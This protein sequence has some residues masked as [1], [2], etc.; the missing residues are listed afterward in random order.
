MKY[1]PKWESGELLL[2]NMNSEHMMESMD[3]ENDQEDA[4]PIHVKIERPDLSVL[5]EKLF[6]VYKKQS[7]AN[8]LEEEIEDE[9]LERD[10]D[11]GNTSFI[12]AAI[13]ITIDKRDDDFRSIPTREEAIVPSSVS[14]P[15][16][17]PVVQLVNTEEG[18]SNGI[19]INP[20]KRNREDDAIVVEDEDSEQEDKKPSLRYAF[21][22]IVREEKVLT[23]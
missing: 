13:K 12:N 21:I 5:M 17:A 23:L 4:T 9:S 2:E 11:I 1:Y 10:I 22:I 18:V 16:S 14:N 20:Q 7:T 8:N 19:A 15:I 3:M 6:A